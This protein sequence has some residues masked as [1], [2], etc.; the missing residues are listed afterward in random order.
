MPDVESVND[1][2]SSTFIPVG[3]SNERAWYLYQYIQENIDV[4]I[5]ERPEKLYM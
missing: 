3:L 4:I 1:L 5:N 2:S